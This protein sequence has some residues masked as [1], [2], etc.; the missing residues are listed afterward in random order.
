M[1]SWYPVEFPIERVKE[2]IPDGLNWIWVR[3]Q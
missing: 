1:D 2:I 3:I